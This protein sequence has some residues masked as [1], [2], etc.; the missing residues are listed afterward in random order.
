MLLCRTVSLLHRLL[1][2]IVPLTY[3]KALWPF[4]VFI[5]ATGSRLVQYLLHAR[6][7]S[8]YLA[9]A[10]WLSW[11][12]CEFPNSTQYW[13]YIPCGP[14][15]CLWERE[16]EL[17]G[18]P[19]I[20]CSHCSHSWMQL[21]GRTAWGYSW[22]RCD[23]TCVFPLDACWAGV[24][25]AHARHGEALVPVHVQK[26][27]RHGELLSV[28]SHWSGSSW[29]QVWRSKQTALFLL[30]CC[31]CCCCLSLIMTLTVTELFIWRPG[32]INPRT[33]SL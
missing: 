24:A 21:R 6:S 30:C 32:S 9:K 33:S 31:C 28:K 29:K 3:W 12:S 5:L 16:S 22:A 17:D 14:T 11:G 26:V 1:Q 27:P 7:W 10:L 8:N 13:M 25:D 20:K 18:Q 23:L 4:I 15:L 2:Q 19:V